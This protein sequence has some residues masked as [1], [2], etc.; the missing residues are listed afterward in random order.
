MKK[1]GWKIIGGLCAAAALAC[2]S[3][4]SNPASPAASTGSPHMVVSGPVRLG[5]S[6]V[7]N[8]PY[9]SGNTY[10]FGYIYTPASSSV[11]LTIHNT[12]TAPLVLSGSSPYVAISADSGNDVF[13]KQLSTPKVPKQTIPAGESTQCVIKLTSVYTGA[14]LPYTAMAKISSNDPDEPDF[15]LSLTG[16]IGC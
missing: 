4:C 16:T 8:L 1:N 2:L 5:D 11:T 6:T 12:G 7:V 10:G 3:A 15:T 9:C 14:S 13:L